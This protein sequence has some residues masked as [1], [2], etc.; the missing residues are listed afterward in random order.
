MAIRLLQAQGL[1][2]S[3][4][5]ELLFGRTVEELRRIEKQGLAELKAAPVAAFR[6]SANE[7]WG[8][9][10]L[11]DDFLLISRRGRA[12]SDDMRE[13]IL[14]ALHPEIKTNRRSNG[15]TKGVK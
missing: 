2:L 1:P 4:I 8:V 11:D 6:P 9:T 3:R 7:T 5:R 15:T 13:R 14:A 10:P 12:L